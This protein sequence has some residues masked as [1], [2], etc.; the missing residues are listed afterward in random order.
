MSYAFGCVCEYKDGKFTVLCGAHQAAISD[1]VEVANLQKNELLKA[2]DDLLGKMGGPNSPV[3]PVY[4][5]EFLAM[6]LLVDRLNGN[7][8]ESIEKRATEKRK[9]DCK[10]S[11]YPPAIHEP[12]CPIGQ[13]NLPHPD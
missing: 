11:A 4:A 8:V 10:L 12:G 13:E 6:E 3:M 5:D 7:D 2:A 1:A 9:C